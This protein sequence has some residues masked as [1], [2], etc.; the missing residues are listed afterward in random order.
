MLQILEEFQKVQEFHLLEC[1]GNAPLR[2]VAQGILRGTVS[3][4]ILVDL[5]S[6]KEM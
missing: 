5:H 1:I 3:N 2:Q 4:G 6:D